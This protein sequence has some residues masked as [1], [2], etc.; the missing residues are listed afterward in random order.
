MKRTLLDLNSVLRTVVIFVCRELVD[1][2]DWSW[3]RIISWSILFS[4]EWP[5]CIMTW[6]N[7]ISGMTWKRILFEL[8]IDEE[9]AKELCLPLSPWC[10]IHAW[11]VGFV[12]SITHESVM[13]F[14]KKRKFSLRFIAPLEIHKKFGDTVYKL[15]FPPH[16][17]VVHL[18]FYVFL[19][20]KYHP[21]ILILYD[22]TQ[23]IRSQ[24]GGPHCYSR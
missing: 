18:V 19:L 2:L 9:Y 24:W 10:G 8:L 15:V 7:T 17:S 14:G 12:R 13:R 22:W 6:S 21:K 5:K 3:R 16:L 23:F 20:K 4:K 1:S 11:C